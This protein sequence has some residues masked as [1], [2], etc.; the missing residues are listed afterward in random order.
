M[1]KLLAVLSC[2]LLLAACAST[3]TSTSQPTGPSANAVMRPASGSQVHGSVTLA[4][5]GNAVRVNTELAG[6]PSGL[7]TLRIHEKGD[8]SKPDA[9]STGI[10]E[11]EIGPLQPDEYGKAA[12][13]YR[14]IHGCQ[15]IICRRCQTDTAANRFSMNPSDDEFWTFAHRIDD[16]GETRKEFFA[17]S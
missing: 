1:N 4:E 16:I 12:Q 6:L 15:T 13:F 7:I 11:R 5:T 17:S 10:F 9:S 3:S 2:P 8:C 14:R